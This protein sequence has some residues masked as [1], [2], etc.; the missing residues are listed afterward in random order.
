MS[1]TSPL[2]A[3]LLVLSFPGVGAGQAH[4]PAGAVP[5]EALDARRVR[6]MDRVQ[7]APIILGSARLRDA[8]SEYPQDSD[9]RQSND[10][11]YLTGLETPDAWLVLNLPET[12]SSVLYLEPRDPTQELWT[13]KKLGPGDEARRQS[14][15]ADVRSTESFR[16]DVAGWL[17]ETQPDRVFADGG[18]PSHTQLLERTLG[19]SAS[20]V[21][22]LAPEVAALRLVKD[23]DEI[24]RL[25]EAVRITSDAHRQAWR[26]AG[27]GVAE[28]E[29]EAIIEYTFRSNGA[30]RVGFPSIVGSGENSVTLHYDKNR[31]TLGEGD[32]VVVDIGA[33]FG[34]YTADLTRTFPVSGRFDDRQ[35][36]IYELVLGAQNA[37][38]EAVRPGVTVGQLNQIARRYLNEH[39]G[40]LCGERSCL[41]HFPHGLSHW[42][43]MDVHDVGDY[44]TPLEAGMVLTIEPGIYLEGEN[45]G[46]RIEDDV[47]VTPTGHELLS[48]SLPREPAEIEAIMAEDPR[49]PRADASGPGAG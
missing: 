42:L 22:T 26:M 25:K 34:Y 11:F 5:G 30:E 29:L 45:L 24:R 28:Y 1:V 47:L 35:R 8:E 16:D 21:H 33:E 43:G 18:D 48:A 39:S 17:S 13:G 7:G 15:M 2:K 6:L 14:G 20:A 23:E 9:F 46:V 44:G 10:F 41:A 38:I 40:D 31:R 27:P 37:A 4:S 19:G 12:G 32:L 36:A 3:L 49:R